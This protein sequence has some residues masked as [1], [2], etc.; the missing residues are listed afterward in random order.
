M[1]LRIVRAGVAIAIIA[2]AMLTPMLA[3]PGGRL[4]GEPTRLEEP[5]PDRRQD[6]VA[7]A[8]GDNDDNDDDEDNDDD[9]D[10]NNEDDGDNEDDDEDNDDG[11]DNNEDDDNDD[12]N[13][14]DDSDNDDDA[15]NDE[16][17]DDDEDFDNVSAPAPPAAPASAPPA[18]ASPP[19]SAGSATEASGTSTGGDSTVALAG[20]RVVVTIFP[21]MPAG[22]TI[23]VRLVDPS[24]VPSPPGT[25]VGD[26]VFRIE[27]RDGSGTPLTTLPAEVNLAVHYTDQEV[28][29]LNEQQATLSWFDPADNRWKPAPKLATDPSTNY[30]AASVTALGTYAVSVP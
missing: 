27:A 7:F 13:D 10:D 26:L 30:V 20:D 24:T 23:T 2:L 21:W 8:Q 4:S 1:T 5:Y 11:D 17:D 19:T 14:E 29:G 22:V 3:G 16:G 18:V 15:D 9:G 6:A 12:D 28:A 25:R